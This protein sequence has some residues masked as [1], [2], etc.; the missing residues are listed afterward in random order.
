MLLYIIVY[1]EYYT[2]LENSPRN[3]RNTTGILTRSNKRNFNFFCTR[4]CTGKALLNCVV[5]YL[6]HEL[7]NKS[8]LKWYSHC[9]QM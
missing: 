2:V 7:Q 4:C 5:M 6:V 1:S 3:G 8:A 9:V